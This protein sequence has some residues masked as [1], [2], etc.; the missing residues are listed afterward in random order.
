MTCL[1][2]GIDEMNRVLVI[3]SATTD[4]VEQLGISTVKM[5]GVV[6]YAG[7]TFRK[8]GLHTAAVS[9]IATQDVAL[10]RILCQ[11]DIQ[12]FNGATKTTTMFVNHVDGDERWQ[13]MPIRATPITASQL[14]RTIRG[15]DHIHLGP[16]HPFDIERGLLRLAPRKGV[17]VTLDI[18]GYVRRVEKGK[19]RPGISEDLHEAL[20]ACTV[21]KADRTEL[22]AILDAYQMRID[23]LMNAY[24]LSEIV[25]TAGRE[26][27]RVVL[28]SG[29]EVNYKARRANHLVDTT[30]AGDVFFAAYLVS[31]LH[32]R[33]GV[34]VACKHAALIAA[35]QVQGRYIPEDCLRVET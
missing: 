20:L 9:N 10:F 25:V 14:Q 8:H 6:T 17:W 26:G 12:L 13:E 33:C 35:R 11:Q 2:V 22:Q 27:G 21:I 5:G 18:Q 3:G 30:G 29:E 23:E 24:K 15:V 1:L 7:I 4:R 32:Q 31:R 28:A 19:V 16:L 34:R